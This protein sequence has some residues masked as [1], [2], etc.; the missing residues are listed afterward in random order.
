[1][2]LAVTVSLIVVE[3]INV[4]L[5]PV[6]V[7]VKVPVLAVGEALNVILDLLEPPEASVT[8]IGLTVIVA[9]LGGGEWDNEAEPLNPFSD[10]NVIVEAPRAP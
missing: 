9:P 1:M 3:C 7:I 5:V 6:R 10:V 8:A 2:S 4:P